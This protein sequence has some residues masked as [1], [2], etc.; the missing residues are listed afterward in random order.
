[1]GN[2]KSLMVL[3]TS[4]TNKN[5]T[6]VIQE[7]FNTSFVI[8]ICDMIG[9]HFNVLSL[10]VSA[11]M[12]SSLELTQLIFGS[13]FHGLLLKIG[14]I[15]WER[16]D[17]FVDSSKWC[18]FLLLLSS[19]WAPAELNVPRE[20]QHSFFLMAG[21]KPRFLHNTQGRR[22]S[23]NGSHAYIR[24]KLDAIFLLSRDD[25]EMADSNAI[26]PLPQQLEACSRAFI[27]A[28]WY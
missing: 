6:Q 20:G 15:Q 13:R 1:M 9:K 19:C 18:L 27:L 10:L 17:F 2:Y 24:I 5:P 22:T 7:V 8:K 14:R 16:N 4:G 11:G 25:D 21:Q 26:A 28:T 23:L 12:R 3:P